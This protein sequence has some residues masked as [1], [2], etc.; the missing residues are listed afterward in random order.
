MKALG[1]RGERRFWVVT[2]LKNPAVAVTVAV[3]M[4]QRCAP[5]IGSMGCTRV[6]SLKA[7]PHHSM[8]LFGACPR[9][10]IVEA[11]GTAKMTRPT[12]LRSVDEPSGQ[13]GVL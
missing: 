2:A 4:S 6:Y 7:P 5:R 13:H 11:C 9:F 1:K 10:S 12:A 8:G 3:R